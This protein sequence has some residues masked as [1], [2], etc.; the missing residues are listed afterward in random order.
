MKSK[1]NILTNFYLNANYY[2]SQN[3]VAPNEIKTP[4][5]N[6][7]NAG[8]STSFKFNG[9]TISISLAGNNLLNKAYYDHLSRFKYFGL[10]NIGRNF[11]LN[12]HLKFG[13]KLKE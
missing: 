4:K 1:K 11:S 7:I 10:L 9:K 5:Y 3:K 2:F 8:V 6:L 13:N 12:C